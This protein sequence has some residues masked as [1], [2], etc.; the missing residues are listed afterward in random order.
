MVGRWRLLCWIFLAIVVNWEIIGG[1]RGFKEE[2]LRVDFVKL[3][4]CFMLKSG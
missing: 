3:F 4:G 1:C 2:N